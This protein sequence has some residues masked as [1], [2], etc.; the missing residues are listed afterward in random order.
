MKLIVGIGN[1]GKEYEQTRHNLGFRVVDRLAERWGV[2]RMKRRFHARMAE[3]SR[4]DDR[5]ALMKPQTFVNESGLAVGEAARWYKAEPKDVLVVL[6]DFNLS[7]GRAKVGAGGSAGG[8]N[9]MTSIIQVL[10]TNAF[11]RLRM[12]IGSESVRCDRDFVLSTFRE[13][14]LPAVEEMLQ[15]AVHAVLSW[16]DDGIAICM[17]RFNRRPGEAEDAD[18]KEEAT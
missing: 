17:N 6:D 4:A 18:T 10:G 16:L 15:T 8:H 3:V 14:E 13:D 5:L 7:V 11:P 9:G 2:A 1:P 12:G